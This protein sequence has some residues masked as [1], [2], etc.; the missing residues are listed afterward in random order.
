MK[1]LL[2]VKKKNEALPVQLN[3]DPARRFLDTVSG[4]VGTPAFNEAESQNAEPAEV[5]HTDAS[6]RMQ[7]DG[8]R[9][10]TDRI[11]TGNTARYG[12]GLGGSCRLSSLRLVLHLGVTLT[13]VEDLVIEKYSGQACFQ[14]Y[15]LIL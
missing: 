11:G 4:I 9:D 7:T 2:R 3:L 15:I 12:G 6:G 5:V 13:D 8:G 10:A 14:R 1:S